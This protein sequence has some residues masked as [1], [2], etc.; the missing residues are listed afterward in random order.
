MRCENEKIFSLGEVRHFNWVAVGWLDGLRSGDIR[1]R[2]GGEDCGMA[3]VTDFFP[4][5]WL[6]KYTYEQLERIAIK[7]ESGIPDDE[8]ERQMLREEKIV[9]FMRV[10]E[11]R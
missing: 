8:A 4:A 10:D 1:G 7:T 9:R 3:G 6:K 5:H 2:T 11:K